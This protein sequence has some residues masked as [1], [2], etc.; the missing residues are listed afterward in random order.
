MLNHK[1]FTC[2][3]LYLAAMEQYFK[4]GKLVASTGLK[5]ELILQ[6]NLG[7]AAS[8]KGL[9]AILLKI[10]DS[11]IPILYSKQKLKAP[12][13]PW[14]KLEGVDIM[15]VARK[16]YQKKFGCRQMTLKISS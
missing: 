15:E 16:T 6:H 12:M 10:K 2:G 4:I 9:D 3:S 5:G 14:I 1:V 11:F 13:K 7:K 8:L